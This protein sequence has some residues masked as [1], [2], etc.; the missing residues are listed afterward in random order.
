MLLVHEVI[1]HD[2]KPDI[3]S[4][5]LRDHF[6]TF[7]CP[8]SGVLCSKSVP[9]W[10]AKFRSREELLET[11]FIALCREKMSE[12]AKK[13]R[14]RAV[15]WA[16]PFRGLQARFFPC[17]NQEYLRL[18]HFFHGFVDHFSLLQS[19]QVQHPAG[20]FTTKKVLIHD[21]NHVS[22]ESP[23]IQSSIL[24]VRYSLSVC[25]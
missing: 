18:N 15:S 11:I 2:H 9:F 13:K 8:A 22:A 16:C 12:N 5:P 23:V 6:M 7:L 17:L 14:D 24:F 19:R 10:D 25:L 1:F 3:I 4:C 20:S 21:A